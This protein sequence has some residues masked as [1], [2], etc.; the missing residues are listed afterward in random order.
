MHGCGEVH[1][2]CEPA[3]RNRTAI[4]GLGGGVGQRVTADRVDDGRPA[5]FLQGLALLGELGAIDHGHRTE[6][7][8]VLD[9]GG[10]AGR[11]CDAE[12]CLRQECD[13]DT[14]DPPV[15]PVTR[16]SP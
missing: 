4:A 1:A 14:A 5:L 3:R 8:Q 13:R 9:L 6:L 15:A 7:L 10:L 12:P 2:L 11:R 16:T